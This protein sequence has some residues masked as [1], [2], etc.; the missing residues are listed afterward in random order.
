VA[1]DGNGGI[2]AALRRFGVLKN[3]KERGVEYIHAYCVDN[4]L[5]KVADPLFIGYCIQ[6]GAQC[7]A[8]VVRKLAPDEPVGVICQKNNK[9]AVVEYSEIPAAMAQQTKPSG[10]LSFGAANIANHFYTLDFLHTIEKLENELEYH[11]AKKKIKHVNLQSGEHVTPKENNGMKMEL[12]VFDVFPFVEKMAV[13]EVDRKE[14]FSPLK[15]APGSGCDCPETSRRDII[16]QHIRFVEKHQG[17]VTCENG[18]ECKPESAAFELSPLVT[19]EGEGLECVQGKTITCPAII[20]NLD[21][22]KKHLK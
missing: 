14:D 1:P 11:I 8:K 7:G 6:K 18:G 15:N 13:L 12:F 9:F 10:E 22:L 5:V 16:A 20:E 17:K 3:M 19:Y 2:Y 4:C 21:Q